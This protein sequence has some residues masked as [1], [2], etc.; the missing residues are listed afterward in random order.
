MQN[1]THRSNYVYLAIIGFCLVLLVDYE[2]IQWIG[3]VCILEYFRRFFYDKYKAF[4]D[5]NN[6]VKQ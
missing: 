6:Q 5:K 2:K 3:W 4:K 1:P